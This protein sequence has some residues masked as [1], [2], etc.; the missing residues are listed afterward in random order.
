MGSL[1][2][3]LLSESADKRNED[4][5]NLEKTN[6][7]ADAASKAA[8]KKPAKPGI[9]GSFE[10]GGTVPKTGDYHLHKNE[11]VIPASRASEYRKVYMS[12]KNKKTQG[13]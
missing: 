6:A 7:D 5:A 12:R 10:K 1:T 9:L 3:M 8:A 13:E 4:A 11:E 2:S